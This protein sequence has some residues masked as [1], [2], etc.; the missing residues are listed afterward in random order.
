MLAAS[1]YKS[2][3]RREISVARIDIP[4]ATTEIAAVMSVEQKK[5]SLGLSL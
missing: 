2:E 1:G 5:I 3:L 4:V